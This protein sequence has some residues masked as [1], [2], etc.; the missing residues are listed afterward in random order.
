MPARLVDRA[1]VAERTMA[2]WFEPDAPLRFTPGQ[3]VDITVPDPLFRDDLGNVRTFSI[4]SLPSEPRLMVTTRLG[5]SAFKRTLAEAPLGLPVDLDGPYGSFTLHQNVSKPAVF[6]AGGIGI[7]PFHSIIGDVSERRVSRPLTLIYS[8]RTAHDVAWLAD[9]EA[10]A[11]VNPNFRLVATL[12]APRP[13]E[14]WTHDTG[15]V[16][17]PFLASHLGAPSDLANTIFYV[18]GPGRFV[19]AM[20]ALLPE[21]GADPDNIRAEEF[22]GY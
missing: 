18:A 17:K 12:T 16:D 3:T 1:P 6:L 15:R 9:L 19:T 10:W 22:P 7:T 21:V 20:Q 13:G 11:R 8:N 4:A 2:F 5:G 14:A